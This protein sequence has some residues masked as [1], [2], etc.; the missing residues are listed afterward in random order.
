MKAKLK[1]CNDFQN[2]NKE[3]INFICYIATIYQFK[4]IQ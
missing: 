3:T 4:L 2:L 1:M